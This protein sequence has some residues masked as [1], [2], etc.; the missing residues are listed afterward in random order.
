[1]SWIADR[2]ATAVVAALQELS[3]PSSVLGEFSNSR[4][5]RTTTWGPSAPARGDR[6]P[7]VVDLSALWAGP[8]AARLLGLA[9]ARVVTLEAI[10][11]PD[12]M[13]GGTEGFYRDLH[14]GNEMVRLDFRTRQGRAELM[15]F[16]RTADIVIEASRPRALR[17]M[18]L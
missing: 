14:A 4:A 1:T 10:N 9:G 16:V 2:P 17:R 11:R 6:V 13:R 8:L 18:G 3:V 15:S 7:V 12:R 5:V